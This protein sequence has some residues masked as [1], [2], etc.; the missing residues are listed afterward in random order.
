MTPPM[1]SVKVGAAKARTIGALYKANSN[2][3]NTP[4]GKFIFEEK[5]A[6]GL[7]SKDANKQTGEEHAAGCLRQPSAF[8]T[9]WLLM[10]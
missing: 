3:V 10:A 6:Y 5:H 4:S 2:V 7:V 8:Y 1:E 9:L